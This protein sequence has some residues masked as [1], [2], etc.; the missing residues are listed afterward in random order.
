MRRRKLLIFAV[1]AALLFAVY[2]IYWAWDPVDVTRYVPKDSI[3][4]LEIN[5]LLDGLNNIRYL[6]IVGRL[7]KSVLQ[8][9]LLPY[10]HLGPGIN[11]APSL[12]Y[13]FRDAFH[14]NLGRGHITTTASPHLRNRIHLADSPDTTRVYGSDHFDYLSIT[15]P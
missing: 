13:A 14:R 1:S 15:D 10:R 12:F 7:P 2:Y 11:P 3:A 6:E 9:A 8:E 4:V 5:D